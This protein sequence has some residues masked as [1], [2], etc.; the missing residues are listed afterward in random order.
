VALVELVVVVVVVAV[1]AVEL[2]VVIAIV[3]VVVAVAAAAVVVVV[4]AAVDSH[5]SDFLKVFRV[6]LLY[7]LLRIISPL[8]HIHSHICLT[9]SIQPYQLAASLNN[10]LQQTLPQPSP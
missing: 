4:A 2:V 5:L 6:V 9:E 7:S 10:E 3:V 8:L 1:V